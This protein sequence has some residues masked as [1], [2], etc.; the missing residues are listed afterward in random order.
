MRKNPLPKS[1]R[2]EVVLGDPDV[3]SQILHDLCVRIRLS[4]DRDE[5]VSFQR[6]ERRGQ[7]YVSTIAQTSSV[8][9]RV[10]PFFPGAVLLSEPD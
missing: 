4:R 3:Q 10:T 2:L 5:Q 9:D 1:F 8:M 6:M 7:T